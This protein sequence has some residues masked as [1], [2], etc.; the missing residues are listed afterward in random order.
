MVVYYRFLIFFWSSCNSSIWTVIYY[1]GINK[2][3]KNLS[4]STWFQWYKVLYLLVI[5][6]SNILSHLI[7]CMLMYVVM[8]Y[9]D[10]SKF[11]RS[12]LWSDKY[13]LH[14][15]SYLLFF[16]LVCWLRICL[17]EPITTHSQKYIFRLT[18]YIV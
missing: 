1:S 16:M 11:V 9:I 7:E 6:W 5:T 12:Y 18:K 2:I 10:T 17:L 15:Q 3:A 13:L 4:P 8:L 14:L